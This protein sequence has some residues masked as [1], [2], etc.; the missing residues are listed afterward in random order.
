MEGERHLLDPPGGEEV[1]GHQD[2]GQEEDT[3]DEDKGGQRKTK[4]GQKGGQQVEEIRIKE[5]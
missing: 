2:G 5:D 1:E 3:K 4:R